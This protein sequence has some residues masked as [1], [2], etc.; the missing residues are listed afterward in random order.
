LNYDSPA[1][2]RAVLQELGIGL[3]KRWGQNFLVSA[4]SRGRIVELFAPG[5]EETIWEIGPGL[6][7]LTQELLRRCRRVIA[8]EIDHGLLR[9]L[10]DNFGPGLELVAGDAL[11][12]WGEALDRY[13]PPDG[14]VGNLP[15]RAAS[16]IIGS[17]AEAGFA[18]RRLVFTVQRELAARMASPVGRKSY[19]SFSVLCQYAYRVRE[20]FTIRP[21]AFFPAPEVMSA[22]VEL[23][24]RGGVEER[25]FRVFFAGLVRALFR[26]RRKTVWNNLLAWAPG[27]TV[28][29]ERLRAVLADERI[30]PGCRGEELSVE[31]LAS[32]GRRLFAELQ[33]LQLV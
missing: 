22:V 14:V 11:E 16:A 32:L 27:S 28:G 18:P 6:G 4:G 2:I 9:F 3:K 15:Y 24:P 21:G 29:A 26:A 30:D 8:F 12:R 5:A 13:G 31:A 23:L 33:E 25:G 1:E 20:R 10:A 19:S 7:C 17:F